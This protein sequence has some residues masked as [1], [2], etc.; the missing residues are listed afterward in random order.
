MQANPAAQTLRLNLDVL[1]RRRLPWSV[2]LEQRAKRDDTLLWDVPSQ[3][4]LTVQPHQHLKDWTTLNPWIIPFP[5]PWTK[6]YWWWER[7]V[8]SYLDVFFLIRGSGALHCL[9]IVT[10]SLGCSCIPT[11]SPTVHQK[12][13]NKSGFSIRTPYYL[14]FA[15]KPPY[16]QANIDNAGSEINEKVYA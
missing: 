3:S 8:L 9:E 15:L 12:T 14:P 13:S 6:G 7:H 16:W 2:V 4:A 10:S 1:E 5:W 11:H